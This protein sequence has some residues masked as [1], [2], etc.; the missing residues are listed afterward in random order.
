MVA[1]ENHE[2]NRLLHNLCRIGTI[3]ELDYTAKKVR[4][5]TGDNT[6]NWLDWPADVGRNYVRFKPLRRD[7]QVILVCPS[8]DISQ[9]HI[10]GDL[11]SA[12]APAP[13]S[14]ADHLD[15]VEFSD[16]TT[17]S[18]DIDQSLLVFDC[19]GN[20]VIHCSDATISASGN[21]TI[22]ADGDATITADGNARI[23]AGGDAEVSAVGAASVSGQTV[24][25]QDGRAGGV[26]CQSH[27]CSFTGG[28]HPQASISITGGN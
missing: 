12:S 21:A 4:V 8:G 22:T 2:L 15:V 5:K 26:V 23:T 19:A 6:T 1:M 16:G 14:S 24:T 25:L 9:A 13:D 17:I 3:A 7:A 18:Y 27:V 11:Y 10:I 28:P 20:T